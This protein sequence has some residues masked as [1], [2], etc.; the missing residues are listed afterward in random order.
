MFFGIFT[1][2]CW[3][4]KIEVYAQ[5]HAFADFIIVL[6]LIVIVLYATESIQANGSQLDTVSPVDSSH[7]YNS[8]GFSV[9]AFEGIGVILPV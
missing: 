6:T 5:F 7:W 4:R 1:L 8:I 2:L 9:Y 3:V